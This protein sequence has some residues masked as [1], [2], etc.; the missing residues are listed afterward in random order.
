MNDRSTHITVVITLDRAIC[1]LDTNYSNLL[2]NFLI[3]NTQLKV[4][5]NEQC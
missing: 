2:H 3:R 5:H 4:M 1:M